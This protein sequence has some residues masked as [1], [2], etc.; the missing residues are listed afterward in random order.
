MLSEIQRKSDLHEVSCFEEKNGS[1][2]SV[3]TVLDNEENVTFSIRDFGRK[4]RRT[5]RRR[6]HFFHRNTSKKTTE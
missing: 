2:Y 3:C 1:K 6:K 4:Y 5:A